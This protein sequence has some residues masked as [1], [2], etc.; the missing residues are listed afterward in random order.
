MMV[1]ELMD[2]A[3]DLVAKTVKE[4]SGGKDDVLG[5]MLKLAAGRFEDSPFG[6]KYLQELRAWITDYF[7]V[8]GGRLRHRGGPGD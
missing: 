1:S 7:G 5:F 4:M 8:E 2:K 6:E 3:G